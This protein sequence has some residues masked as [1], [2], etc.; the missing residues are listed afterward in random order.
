M[1]C[2]N[3]DKLF[4]IKTAVVLRNKLLKYEI[5]QLHGGSHIWVSVSSF[6]IDSLKYL[7]VA[8]KGLSDECL[9]IDNA[10]SIETQLA[11]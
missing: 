10:V 3:R 4:T 11:K 8:E 5:F 2:R 7:T 9:I 6:N 1:I